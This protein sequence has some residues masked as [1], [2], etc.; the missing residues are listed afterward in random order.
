MPRGVP[1]LAHRGRPPG[2]RPGGLPRAVPRP[3]PGAGGLRG[4][5]H[6]GPAGLAPARSQHPAGGAG[7]LPVHVNTLRYRLARYTDLT[8]CDPD[9]LVGVLWAVEL[10]DVTLP[11]DRLL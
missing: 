8:G 11:D 9:D 2:G 5:H 3:G 7:A 1:G 4:R 10:A 6:G